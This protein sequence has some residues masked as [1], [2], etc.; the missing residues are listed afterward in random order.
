M[1]TTQFTV[2]DLFCG[3]GGSTTGAA[4]VPGVEVT[5]AINHWDRAV[6]THAAN[7]G[8]D[9]VKCDLVEVHPAAFEP[10]TVLIGSPECRTHSPANGQKRTNIGQMEIFESC[11]L[12][13]EKIK[14]RAT[15]DTM[16]RW[17]SVHSPEFVIVE[18]VVEVWTKGFDMPRWCRDWTALGYERQE[19]YVNGGFVTPMLALGPHG[20]RVDF[21]MP[22]NRDRVYFVFSKRGNPRPDVEIRPPATCGWCE[23]VV[24]GVQTW[25]DTAFTRKMG[26]IGKYDR[27]Y[28]YTCPTCR[29][30]VEP[31]IFAASN[32]IDFRRSGLRIGDREANGRKPL[33]PKTV[34]RIRHGLRT[35]GLRPTVVADR[36]SSGV[37]CRVA[38]AAD[39]P[40]PAQPTQPVVGLVET[41]YSHS[42]DG[43]VRPLSAALA[44][45][46]TR[47][48]RALVLANRTHGRARPDDADGLRAVTTGE[49][50]G[51]LT[52]CR[53]NGKTAPADR[54]G[55]PTLAAGG[56]HVGVITTHR[57]QSKSHTTDDAIGT[58]TAHTVNH[59]VLT[60]LARSDHA[61]RT[62]PTA[63]PLQTQTTQ[64]TLALV[65]GPAAQIT[66][67]GS[68]S[69]DPVSD[70]LGAVIA[71]ARQIGVLS[72]DP[73]LVQY[74]GSMN[75]SAVDDG[76]PTVTTRDRHA[77]VEWDG[78]VVDAAG[79]TDAELD[80]VIE[81]LHFRMLEP[82]ELKV[83]TG[84]P[85]DYALVGTRR[86]RVRLVG[87]SNFPGIEQLLIQ[88]CLATLDR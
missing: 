68:R 67:R 42:G 35:Y 1:S 32:C 76:L 31:L 34:A 71:S 13:P 70:P 10:M 19:V 49:T 4:A 78:G 12:A 56:E 33:R 52:A 73:F 44:T 63:A 86:D 80:R 8:S 53:T 57:G 39:A 27:Q 2:T 15:M 7:H 26:R 28:V 62:H 14:S 72:R 85:A 22:Q 51:L 43:R 64:D 3:A 41:A 18:N 87:G 20:D 47:S 75:A 50:Q 59:G 45:A 37:S 58:V 24:F 54:T 83:G 55:L 40:L 84:Y 38:A 6:E 5:R 16:L 66:L 81:T 11:Q 36:Y 65:T 77:L 88:R 17:A 60:D 69:L 82:E 61:G 21:A 46:S 9:P 25:K 74:Y 29:R 23:A 30:R 79:L 48:T